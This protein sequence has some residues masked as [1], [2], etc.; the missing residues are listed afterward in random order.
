MD[1]D[2]EDLVKEF[3]LPVYRY[4]FIR[5]RQRELSE[6][7]SQVVFLKAFESSEKHPERKLELSYFFTIARNTLI[8]HWRKKK[9]E[10]VA[11]DDALSNTLASNDR[12]AGQQVDTDIA[13]HEV[14]AQLEH[15]SEEYRQTL[16]LRFISN[17]TTE[18]IAQHLGT[19]AAN[20]R[21][22][23]CRGLTKLRKLL[24]ENKTQL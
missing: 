8:D 10:V 13:M 5:V 14:L 24:Q 15:L 6:D 7:L 11:L 16:M 21:Q 9:L 4:I 2:F 22:L 19:T 12:P 1:V 20:I 3:L 23:Q 18:E 17:W